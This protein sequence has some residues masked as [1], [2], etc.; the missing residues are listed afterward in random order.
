[1][2]KK[3]KTI[4]QQHA[5][6]F[7]TLKRAFYEG[8]VAL[9]ECKVKATGEIVAALCA[10]GRDGDDVTMTPFAVFM[11]GNPYE[12]LLPP[13]PDRPGHFHGESEAVGG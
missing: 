13:D 2:P 8:N 9:M 7:E 1:M 4:V 5:T 11:N 3:P 6:N 12:M 10:T